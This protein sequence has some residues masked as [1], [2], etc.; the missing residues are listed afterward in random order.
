M[1]ARGRSTSRDDV[2]QKKKNGKSAVLKTQKFMTRIALWN[3]KIS[4]NIWKMQDRL[5]YLGTAQHNGASDGDLDKT[6]VKHC[7]WHAADADFTHAIILHR[8]INLPSKKD[9]TRGTSDHSITKWRR[10]LER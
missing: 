5:I 4:K 8:A 7:K 3:I 6:F 10:S 9:S 2:E 1:T